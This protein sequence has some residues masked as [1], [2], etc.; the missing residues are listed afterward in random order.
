MALVY[1]VDD[2]KIYRDAAVMLLRKRGV[3]VE[4]FSRPRELL[5]LLHEEKMHHLEMPK[6]VVTDL[7]MPEM[8]GIELAQVIRKAYPEITLFCLTGGD[9]GLI[10]PIPEVMRE[11]GC[12]RIFL[13]PVDFDI[14][15]S[16]LAA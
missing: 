11:L 7:Y 4:A 14:L 12:S 3:D 8:D 9:E 2:E 10:G 15:A 5:A 6:Y 13:K 1:L 16:A